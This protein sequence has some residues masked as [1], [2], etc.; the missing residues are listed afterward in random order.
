MKKKIQQTKD[1]NIKD[2][3]EN[4][5]NLWRKWQWLAYRIDED[6]YHAK[7]TQASRFLM[8]LAD[9]EAHYDREKVSVIEAAIEQYEKPTK[10]PRN[11]VLPKIQILNKIHK[12]ITT[13]G[14]WLV[15]RKQ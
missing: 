12:T 8:K 14:G 7:Q 13:C 1:T 15:Y 11:N 6:R 5:N 2:N 9:L 4:N 3:T 10:K